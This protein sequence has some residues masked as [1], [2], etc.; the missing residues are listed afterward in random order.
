[1]SRLNYYSTKAFEFGGGVSNVHA[2]CLGGCFEGV[3][4]GVCAAGIAV[5][6][7]RVDTAF[8]SAHDVQSFNTWIDPFAVVEWVD[9]PAGSGMEST[10]V[11][12]V[13]R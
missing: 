5:G 8:Q 3:Y 9:D 6:L 2:L 13:R 4:D 11:R 1:M 10:V 12:P 7:E